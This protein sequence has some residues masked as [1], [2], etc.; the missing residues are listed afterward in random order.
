MLQRAPLMQYFGYV[1]ALECQNSHCNVQSDPTYPD[2]IVA[3]TSVYRA[4]S[5][6]SAINM[7][8]NAHAHCCLDF[9]LSESARSRGMAS[10]TR[11]RSVV[12]L[13]RKLRSCY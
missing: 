10:I 4:P 2:I 8:S 3:G 7:R 12:T 5:A 11:K 6:G 13:E 9:E 1:L